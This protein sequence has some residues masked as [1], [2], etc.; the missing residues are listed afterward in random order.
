MARKGAFGHFLDVAK[1]VMMQQRARILPREEG[2]VG[3]VHRYPAMTRRRIYHPPGAGLE[4]D[5]CVA[6]ESDNLD[7]GV[8]RH[9]TADKDDVG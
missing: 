7:G 1:G 5:M 3:S 6:A 9:D 4:V 2:K 8:N